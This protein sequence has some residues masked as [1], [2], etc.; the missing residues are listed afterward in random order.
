MKTKTIKLAISQYTTP[1]WDQHG[2]RQAVAV[3]EFVTTNPPVK[4]LEQVKQAITAVT[5]W[6]PDHDD[7]AHLDGLSMHGECAFKLGANWE[8]YLEGSVVKS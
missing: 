8:F 3:V 6:T 2:E 4:Y 1:R 7:A 5:G